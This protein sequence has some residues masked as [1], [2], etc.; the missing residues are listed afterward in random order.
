LK[1]FSIFDGVNDTSGAPGAANIAV[2]FEKILND[3]NGM[4]RGLGKTDS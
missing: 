4:L 2:N 3:P 1:I